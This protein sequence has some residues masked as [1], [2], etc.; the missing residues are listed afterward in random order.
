M[1]KTNNN[2][3][4]KIHGVEYILLD[5]TEQNENFICS[6]CIGNDLI[7]HPRILIVRKEHGGHP[8]LMWACEECNNYNETGGVFNINEYIKK[9]KFDMKRNLESNIRYTNLIERLENNDQ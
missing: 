4:I 1:A 2:N 8:A 3:Y 7:S 5:A 6:Y 9:M